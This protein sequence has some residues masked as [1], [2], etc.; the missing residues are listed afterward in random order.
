MV[1][2]VPVVELEMTSRVIVEFAMALWVV[3][4]RISMAL[5]EAG[6]FWVAV[7]W[8]QRNGKMCLIFSDIDKG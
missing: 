1:S 3:V 2:M 5:V 4:C 7:L 6:N 8:C